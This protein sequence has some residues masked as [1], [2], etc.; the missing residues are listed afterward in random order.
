MD[1]Y[2][3]CFSSLAIMNDAA[4]HIQAQVSVYTYVFGFSCKYIY[5]SGIA[6]LSLL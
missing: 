1:G 2:L 4:I 6:A 5:M 3:N